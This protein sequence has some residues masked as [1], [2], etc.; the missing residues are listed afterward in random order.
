MSVSFRELAGA[1]LVLLSLRISALCC[2]IMILSDKMDTVRC[3]RRV[4]DFIKSKAVFSPEPGA[5]TG[6]VSL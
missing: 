4:S 6:V 1:H 5:V 2:K 3:N